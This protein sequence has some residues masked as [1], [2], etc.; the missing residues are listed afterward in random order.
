MPNEKYGDK[1]LE[2]KFNYIDK[3]IETN[4]NF[5]KI[6]YAFMNNSEQLLIKQ[7]HERVL[8]K[9]EMKSTITAA[10]KESLEAFLIKYEALE[11]RIERLENKPKDEAYK[12]QNWII[13]ALL[14]IL[15]VIITT[16]VKF[17]L[18]G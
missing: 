7:D 15:I 14:S 12:R 16:Y 10:I 18:F 9:E 17:I 11:S 2:E 1:V 5:R 8:L 13:G 6:V 3:E 4:E